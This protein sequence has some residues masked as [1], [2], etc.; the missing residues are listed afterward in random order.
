MRIVHISTGHL[1]GAGLAA[2]RLNFDLNRFGIQST[3]IALERANFLPEV[4]EKSVRRNIFQKVVSALY[5]KSQSFLDTKSFFSILSMNVL[6]LRRLKKFGGPDEVIFHVHNWFNILNPSKLELLMKKGYKVVITL[7]DQRWMTG[8]CHYSFACRGFETGCRN[9]PEL[10]SILQ[11]FPRQNS[12]RVEK[13]LKDKNSENLIFISPSNWMV[14]EAKQ[15]RNLKD[16]KIV[17]VPNSLGI[18]SPFLVE[19]NQVVGT[20]SNSFRIG[21]AAMDQTSYI[22]GGD[23]VQK[24]KK[25]SF[26]DGS[27]FEFVQMSDFDQKDLGKFWSNIDLLLV[28]SREDNSPNVIAE[29]KYFS[30]K[31]IASEVGGI[32]E[33]LDLDHDILIPESNL[34]APYIYEIL[35]E[36]QERSHSF[37][38]K[39]S[40]ISMKDNNSVELHA[41]VYRKLFKG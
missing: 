20:K 5:S 34:D 27:F 15:S 3:F 11:E 32:P 36:L 33:L 12:K 39:S 40:A 16:V 14:R 31:V 37:P 4:N 35:K 10:P 1:G 26:E 30:K 41:E 9:C 13:L 7:H 17:Q 18:G 19:K 8:G 23:V 2:R 24:L 29:A 38:L 25:M 6:S 28:P 21:L 22:K